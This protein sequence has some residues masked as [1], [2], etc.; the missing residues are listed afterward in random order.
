M[1]VSTCTTTTAN[2]GFL[3]TGVAGGAAAVGTGAASCTY[4]FL[5]ISG[6]Q[7]QATPFAFNDR[8]CGGSI[9]NICS[10]L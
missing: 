2:I 3:L 6:G 8:Y 9:G 5:A 1:C 10:M 4:D 7:N